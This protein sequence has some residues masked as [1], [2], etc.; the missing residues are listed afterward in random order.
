MHCVDGLRPKLRGIQGGDREVGGLRR[1]DDV[2]LGGPLV[3]LYSDDLEASLASWRTPISFS[4]P[5]RQ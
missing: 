1:A 4:G 2:R 5:E 3:I